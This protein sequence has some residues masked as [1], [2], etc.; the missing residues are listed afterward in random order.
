MFSPERVNV[1]LSRAR[2]GLVMIGNT[3]TFTKS[4]KGGELWTILVGMLK[5][6]GN[7]YDGLPVVCGKHPNRRSLLKRPDD[8]DKDCPDGGCTLPWYVISF[9]PISMTPYESSSGI[10]LTCGQ[11][12]CPSKCHP[13]VD[14]S[15]MQC[16][17]VKNKKCPNGHVQQW[18]CSKGPPSTCGKCD[19]ERA[20]A[21]KKQQE[22]FALQMKRDAEEQAHAHQMAELDAELVRE[23]EQAR[24]TRQAEE[25][26]HAL[27]QKRLDVQAAISQAYSAVPPSAPVPSTPTIPPPTQNNSIFQSISNFLPSWVPSAPPSGAT[28]STQPNSSA[29]VPSA[30]KVMVPKPSA[31]RD[32]WQ[33]QKFANGV[34]SPAID[35]IMSMTGLEDVKK[36]VLSIRNKVDTS[37]RQGTDLKGERFNVSMLGNPGTGAPITDTFAS[38]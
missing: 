5:E 20:L 12:A 14:H 19:R 18:K 26:K 27:E 37:I 7:V 31:A 4:R 25:R 38:L 24:A 2:N 23:R 10:M 22:Q 3:Q 17:K 29:N 15:K 36:Q 11:H 30:P 6:K 32:D 16:D 21:E 34:Q 9:Y 1:L 13:L 28:S 8:F 35:A 33:Y